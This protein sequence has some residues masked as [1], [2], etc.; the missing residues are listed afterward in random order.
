MTFRNYN[1]ILEKVASI[2]PFLGLECLINFHLLS[3]E[4]LLLWKG[5]E[6]IW[7]KEGLTSSSDIMRVLILV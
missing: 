3:K 2:F 5:D 7:G 1:L 6:V 4:L